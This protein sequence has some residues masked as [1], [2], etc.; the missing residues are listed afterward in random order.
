MAPLRALIFDQ[1]KR[2]RSQR[3]IVFWYG[4][5]SRQELFYVEDFDR[6]QADYDNFRWFTAL[7]EPKPEDDWEGFTGFIHAVAYEHYLKDHPAPEECEYYLCGPTV[8]IRAVIKMLDTLGVEQNN[9]LFDD[10][11][12]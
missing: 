12:G 8:M 7:S 2:R 5:R 4:A 1:L 3:N 9:I 6:L 11:G 10:F